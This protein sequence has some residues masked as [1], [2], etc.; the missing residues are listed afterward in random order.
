LTTKMLASTMH[1]STNNQPHPTTTPDHPDTPNP[2]GAARGMRPEHD[3]PETTATHGGCSLRTQQGAQTP[4]PTP[5]T[6]N[7]PPG[8]PGQ[9]DQGQPAHRTPPGGPARCAP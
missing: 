4:A 5:A 1:I 9:E 2:A 3:R 8:R 7:P 6:P